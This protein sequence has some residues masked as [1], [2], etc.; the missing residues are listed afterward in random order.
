LTSSAREK[1]ENRKKHVR[2]GLV[3]VICR[4]GFLRTGKMLSKNCQKKGVP[5]GGTQQT[6]TDGGPR[7]TQ[8]MRGEEREK[9][10]DNDCHEGG[11]M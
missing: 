11:A 8:S 5:R 3:S 10:G 4:P 1:K 6:E 9:T 7:G 2:G